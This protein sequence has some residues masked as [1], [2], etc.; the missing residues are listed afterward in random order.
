MNAVIALVVFLAALGSN[1]LDVAMM[2]AIGAGD[3]RRA[4]LLSVGTWAATTVAL[5]SFVELGVWVLALEGSGLYVG[6]RLAMR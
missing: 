3:G 6:A 1:W 4:A 5:V 2:R